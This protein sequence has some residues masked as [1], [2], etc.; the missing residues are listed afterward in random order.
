MPAT[1]RAQATAPASQ[2]ID[3]KLIPP[4]F[5]NIHDEARTTRDGAVRWGWRQWSLL[6]PRLHKHIKANGRNGLTAALVK[7]QQAVLPKE[8]H[9]PPTALSVAASPTS[10]TDIVALVNFVAA[11]QQTSALHVPAAEPAPPPLKLI[12]PAPPPAPAAASDIPDSLSI[13]PADIQISGTNPPR[14]TW[15]WKQWKLVAPLVHQHAAQL[16][17][18]GLATALFKAQAQV[19][20]LREQRTLPAMKNACMPDNRLNVLEVIEHIGGPFKAD[21][22]KF[23]PKR[24][25]QHLHIAEPEAAAPEAPEPIAAPTAHAAPAPASIPAS[26]Y[27]ERLQGLLTMPVGAFLPAITAFLKPIIA[28]AVRDMLKPQHDAFT[29]QH[30][31]IAAIV[32]QAVEDAIGAPTPQG[33]GKTPEQPAQFPHPMETPTQAQ[34]AHGVQPGE[35]RMSPRGARLRCTEAQAEVIHYRN[36]G[37]GLLGHL[38]AQTWLSYERPGAQ[39]AAEQPQ[40]AQQEAPAPIPAALHAEE[41]VKPGQVAPHDI[42]D[43]LE[44]AAKALGIDTVKR[45]SVIV[46]GLHPRTMDELQHAHGRAYRFQYIK[47]DHFNAAAD[48]PASTD[49]LI[50]CRKKLSSELLGTVR[51]YAIPCKSIAN[52]LPAAEWALKEIFQ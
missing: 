43:Q 21:K 45:P 24:G 15:G 52:S 3:P 26:T 20:P 23:L 41:P 32:R 14:I 31:S 25:V 40:D 7:A 34:H 10:G 12:S 27:D 39:D 51:R 28:Q 22:V 6:T 1:A 33:G 44:V 38:P 8:L 2:L 50:L 18:G 46:V 47:Q 42:T 11:M 29:A 35:E 19:L 13:I 16:G 9:R 36:L 4:C 5:Q 37:S 49:A 17:R 30:A 48:L